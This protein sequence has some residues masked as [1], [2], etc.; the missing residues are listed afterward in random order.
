[1]PVQNWPTAG[2][3]EAPAP[4]LAAAAG[5]LD[6]LHALTTNRTPATNAGSRP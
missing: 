2:A 6:V 1:M 5:L 3:L 4:V